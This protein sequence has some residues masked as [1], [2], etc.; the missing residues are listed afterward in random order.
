MKNKRSVI[1][2]VLWIAVLL[3]SGLFRIYSYVLPH[4]LG[5][6]LSFIGLCVF[7]FL[8]PIMIALIFKYRIKK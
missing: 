6:K 5:L 2:T 4:E 3:I 1:V 7:I 8:S